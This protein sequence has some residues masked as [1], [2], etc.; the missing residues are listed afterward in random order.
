[1]KANEPKSRASI[2]NTFLYAPVAQL[3]AG[4]NNETLF[5]PPK[6]HLPL[7]SDWTPKGER[8]GMQRIPKG[9]FPELQLRAP[10]LYAPVAQLDRA[11]PSGGRGQRFESSRAR[12][13]TSFHSA[14]SDFR[15]YELS[16][17]GVPAKITTQF[18][19][20]ST[21]SGAPS[22]VKRPC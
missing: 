22:S 1:M 17:P 13:F 5:H 7:A 6:R 14:C 16:S 8:C 20:A 4:G 2:K 19:Y 15:P 3:G 21:L 10:F 11:L 9:S 18:F 12:H